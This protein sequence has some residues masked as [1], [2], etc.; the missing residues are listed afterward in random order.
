MIW[1]EGLKK[2]TKRLR[3]PFAANEIEWRPQQVGIGERDGNVYIRVLAYVTNRAIMYRLDDV[4]SVGG[5]QSKFNDLPSGGV[6]CGIGAWINEQWVWKWDAA[7]KTDIEAV[8]G[9]RSSA[10][11]RA[12][13]HWG[14]A[15]YLY[16]LEAGFGNI[17]SG[18]QYWQPKGENVKK[19]WKWDGFAWSPPPLPEW[20]LPHKT[21]TKDKP[22]DIVY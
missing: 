17:V 16:Y 14:I 20:A 3:E 22:E 13:V 1:D 2:L 18:G 6:E 19:G 12:A 11:K 15:R 5:W 7:D 4:F 8:K 10:M 21:Q 9:G